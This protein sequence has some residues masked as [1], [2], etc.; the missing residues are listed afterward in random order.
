M[1]ATVELA[2]TVYNMQNDPLQQ[3]LDLVRKML[4]ACEKNRI[5]LEQRIT[6]LLAELTAI[7]RMEGRE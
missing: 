1:T 2:V 6:E 7:S 4:K 5:Q 3:E